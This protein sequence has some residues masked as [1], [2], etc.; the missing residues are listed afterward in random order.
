[1]AITKTILRKMAFTESVQAIAQKDCSKK[2]SRN[3]LKLTVFVWRKI[4]YKE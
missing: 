4:K 1:M 2:I 3:E